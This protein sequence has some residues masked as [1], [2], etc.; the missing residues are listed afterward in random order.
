MI[1][2]GG[3]SLPGRRFSF[4]ARGMPRGMSEQKQENA[5]D[6]DEGE[7]GG[8]AAES[9][10]EEEEEVEQAKQE[11][12][13]LEEGEPPKD[14]ADWPGGKAKYLTYGG[15]DGGES[16]DDGATSKLGP[17]SLRHHEDGSVTI[18]GEEVDNPDEYKGEPIPGG[19]S[20][21]DAPPD[22]AMVGEEDDDM[23][24]DDDSSDDKDSSD[25]DESSDRDS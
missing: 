13:E 4:R 9:A 5:A 23:S 1:R 16:Y 8:G 3:G 10:R 25:D 24:D 14:L 20:D 7:E 12:S 2:G 18:E 19:P 11:M 6:P 15:P 17:S 21:P 22:P